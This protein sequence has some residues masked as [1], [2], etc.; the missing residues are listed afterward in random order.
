MYSLKFVKPSV[1]IVNQSKAAVLCRTCGVEHGN[2]QLGSVSNDLQVLLLCCLA[3]GGVECRHAHCRPPQQWSYMSL[4]SWQDQR[5]LPRKT[6]IKLCMS[7]DKRACNSVATAIGGGS[8]I[9][10]CNIN[11]VDVQD[12]E[13]YTSGGEDD[14]KDSLHPRP[15]ADAFSP[16]LPRD[17]VGMIGAIVVHLCSNL[18]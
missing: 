13:I 15:C 14:T 12:T 4:R 7:S 18:T 10:E 8:T 16:W 2:A 3:S 5:H 1:L 9:S 11:A 6:R 17:L